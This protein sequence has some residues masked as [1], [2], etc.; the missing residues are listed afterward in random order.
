[1]R[2]LP[3]AHGPEATPRMSVDLVRNSVR[4][5]LTTPGRGLRSAFAQDRD[6]AALALG[7]EAV[8]ALVAALTDEDLNI[9][10]A[11]AEALESIGD[12]RALDDLGVLLAHRDKYVR[13]LA[14]G[15]VITL[16][17]LSDERIRAAADRAVRGATDPRAGQMLS[18]LMQNTSM[19]LYQIVRKRARDLYRESRAL[20][21]V[22]Q[23]WESKSWALMLLATVGGILA[24]V[25]SPD[26]AMR[27]GAK[28]AAISVALGTL[29]LP[30]FR[31]YRVFHP[32][33][34]PARGK[35]AFVSP[36]NVT[37]VSILF[38]GIFLCTMGPIGIPGL[39]TYVSAMICPAGSEISSEI[40]MRQWDLPG[41]VVTVSQGPVCSGGAGRTKPGKALQVLSGMILYLLYSGL[42]LAIAHFV[43][44]TLTGRPFFRLRPYAAFFIAMVIFVPLLH[45]T[46]LS[47][48]FRE[49]ISRPINR[50]IYP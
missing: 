32:H 5:A 24:L 31:A 13:H 44:R 11:A 1:M 43:K 46:L 18:A 41:Y 20:Q 26:T 19:N 21:K 27:Y 50:L 10:S 23:I 36:R 12:P 37:A 39:L 34:D 16:L 40:Q 2:R 48:D 29:A 47:P 35:Y 15:V 4:L 14:K 49:F 22:G 7:P 3:G 45:L 6:R 9:Q 8:K 38:F 42:C 17:A 28:L 30:V 33:I 25:I